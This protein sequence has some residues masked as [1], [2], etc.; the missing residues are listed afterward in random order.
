[1]ASIFLRLVVA[2][3]KVLDLLTLTRRPEE[4]ANLVRIPSMTLAWEA[5]AF[6]NSRTSSAK[7]KWD[8][9]GPF[10]AMVT[11]FHTLSY[12]AFKIA[13]DS[14]SMHMTNKYGERGSP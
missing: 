8:R 9:R 10:L 3:K 14:L 4:L 11:G 5:E 6:E 12:T 7:N 2:E 13:L 1:M